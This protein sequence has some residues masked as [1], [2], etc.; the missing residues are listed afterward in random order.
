MWP[1]NVTE[2]DFL[3]FDVHADLI[4]ELLEDDSMLPITIGLFGDWGSGKSSILEILKTKLESPEKGVACL[5]FNGWVFEGYDDAKA[6]LL[7]SIIKE[8]ED[9][10]RFG[11]KISDN[12]KDLV[13]SV[14]WMRV[15]G[16][17]MRNIAI[18]AVSA[19]LTGGLSLIAQGLK[20][21]TAKPEELLNK[22]K[23]EEGEAFIKQFL[24]E[25]KLDDKRK[26]RRL[27]S[28]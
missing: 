19:Y 23:G 22:L 24:K 3:G 27:E 1:D 10:K 11:D 13:K 26:I 18:P 14:N 4:K 5:Y 9:S 28:R 6:A 7:E 16:Y 25:S 17:S 20:T 21:A 8:F 12:I 2:V 15:A